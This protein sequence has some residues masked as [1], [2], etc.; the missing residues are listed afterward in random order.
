MLSILIAVSITVYLDVEKLRKMF[1]RKPK[2]LIL[3][4][5][6]FGALTPLCACGTMA[7]VLSLLTTALPWGPIMAFL[8][9]SPLMSPDTF[10][11]M[12][13]FVG[14]KFAI[15]LA[16]ASVL[17]GIFA[18]Y[19]TTYIEKNTSFLNGQLRMAKQT[20]KNSTCRIETESSQCSDK[21]N[22][23]ITTEPKIVY[24]N[25]CVSGNAITIQY[26]HNEIITKLQSIADKLKLKQF[27]KSFFDLGIKK[28][29]PLFIAFVVVAYL[30]SKYVPT[31]W[32]VDLFNGKHFYSVPIAALIGLPLYVADA[33]VAP[34]LQL[35][36]DSGASYGS[37][38]AFMITG[39]GTSLGV[40]GGLS[41]IMKRK[42]IILYTA[43]ILFGAIIF[44][45]LYDLFLV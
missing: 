44:G 39:P 41:L 3:G 27:V 12:T 17:L 43:F 20:V 25:C 28:I 21:C 37:I 35:L 2:T 45:Y 14:L 40:L 7:V 5:V 33:S 19:I 11:M 32:I 8:V 9:S 26:P 1:L 13:G 30:I 29:L 42:A 18:G 38:L 22:C 36:R 23:E 16:V 31:S 4:S 15:A 34:L 6:S 10:V 24:E